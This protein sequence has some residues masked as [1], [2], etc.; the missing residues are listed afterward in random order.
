MAFSGRKGRQVQY[1]KRTGLVNDF[2]RAFL[3]SRDGSV[4][5]GTDEGISRWHDGTL[6]NY[7]E[8]QGLAYFSIR[9]LAED[10]RRRY[11]DRHRARREPLARRP[12]R[13]GRGDHAPADRED[14]GDPRGSRRRALVR[15]ARSRTVPLARR[16]ADRI[17][18]AA[19]PGRQPAFT[20][21]WRTRSGTFWMSGPNAI[22]AVSRRDL[23]RLADHP[24]F[25]PAVTL[26][27]LSDG[28]EATQI[29]GGVAPAGCSDRQRRGL[30]PQQSRTGAHRAA[31]DAARRRLPKVII[32]QVLR[33][34]ARDARLRTAS[35]CRP[36]EGKL[37]DIV[38]P[39]SGCAP[40][41][42]SAFGTCWRHSTT[43]GPRRCGGATAFYTNLP[44]G[45]YRFRVQAFEMN[46]PESVT[47]ASLAIEWRPHFYR[48]RLVPGALR[49][50]VLAGV[51]AAYRIRLRQVHARFRA[52][53]EERNRVAR[54]MHDT[55]IQGCASVSA[56]LEAVVAVEQ[57]HAGSG[58]SCWIT[59]ARRC[60][61][62][63]TRR[64]AQCGIC[65]RA[66][67]AS[68][69]KSDRCWT[70][71]RSRPA[72]PRACRCASRLRGSRWLL[73]PGRGTR[74]S[75]GGARGRV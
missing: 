61:P 49:A 6:T 5:I 19:G 44:P 59:R 58:G 43:I 10:A 48:T 70:R 14:L 12:F 30:V 20:R 15:H 74:Y 4:W 33:G 7:L 28:V 25:H 21:F 63:W 40:R 65:G 73:D 66:A 3:E 31:G 53:L 68:R 27:G 69:R 50:L 18:R 72:M 55:V 23:D 67:T 62:P 46:M 41:S 71:W 38:M 57:E 75:D 36:G 32:E 52:V 37:A 47:E 1:T 16:Q 11:L 51:L 24:G 56:L 64:G 17:R 45:N 39:P 29:Y 34:W 26:Y 8:P 22:L 9:T 60:A 13:P 42:A 54:E 35:W 2:V